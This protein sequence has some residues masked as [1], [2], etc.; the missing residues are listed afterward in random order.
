MGLNEILIWMPGLKL[1]WFWVLIASSV[2]FALFLVITLA[3]AESGT[4]AKTRWFT[5]TVFSFVIMIG[6]IIFKPKENMEQVQYVPA[7]LPAQEN[8]EVPKDTK[9]KKST[10]KTTGNA[11]NQA[12]GEKSQSTGKTQDSAGNA[13]GAQGKAGEGNSL[14]NNNSLNGGKEY[15]DPVLEEILKL[16]QQAEEG[17][18][19]STSPESSQQTSNEKPGENSEKKDIQQN[20]NS[21]AVKASILVASLNVRDKAGMDGGVIG[22]LNIGDLVEVIDKSETGQWVKIR[23]SS[24]KT[25]W[26]MKE[27]L[28][29]S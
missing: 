28:K 8:V 17:G 18:T 25:G 26:V 5:L 14:Q 6:L 22:T 21:Q 7:P 27:Y 3:L 24:G 1:I 2:L 15:R 19:D 29:Y 12:G 4:K 13:Q 23:L 20:Q 10:S 11:S 9:T 16:K